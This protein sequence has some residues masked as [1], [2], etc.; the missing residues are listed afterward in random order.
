MTCHTFR[1]ETGKPIGIVCTRER[2]RRCYGCSAPNASLSC[3][4]CDHVLCTACAVSPSSGLDFCPTCFAGAWRHWCALG[5][6]P[7]TQAER[8]QAF[9][10]W[11]REQP[12]LFLSLSKAR[13]KSSLRDVP[14]LALEGT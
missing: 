5:A 13:T 10:L 9:R 12:A 6:L 8:R 1:D 7:S 11:A 3:D 4:G 14:Q 2:T